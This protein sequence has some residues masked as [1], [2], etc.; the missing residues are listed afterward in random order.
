[1][2]S[3]TASPPP[4]SP[5]SSLLSAS[6]SLHDLHL[7]SSEGG[8]SDASIHPA[9]LT[10]PA[11]SDHASLRIPT[12]S[13]APTPPAPEV[14]SPRSR[15][16]KCKDV[17][18]VAIGTVVTG[19]LVFDSGVITYLHEV[20]GHI[21]L[22]G[23]LTLSYP[24]GIQPSYTV[25]Q[26]TNA[27]DMGRAGSAAEFFSALGNWLRA[28]DI[29]GDWWGHASA[30]KSGAD[31][32]DPFNALG[33]GLG[34][35]QTDAWILL[36]GQLP[37]LLSSAALVHA[38]SSICRERPLTGAYLQSLGYLQHALNL[39]YV[40]WSLGKG[41][42]ALQQAA[43]EGDDF[44]GIAV[45]LARHTGMSAPH[46]IQAMAAVLIP[47]I[48]AVG[49]VSLMHERSHTADAISDHVARQYWLR[50]GGEGTFAPQPTKQA[51]LRHMHA[52]LCES[53]RDR[54]IRRLGTANIMA[55]LSMPILRTVG[56][57]LVPPLGHAMAGVTAVWPMV[58]MT[59]AVAEA[60]QLRRDLQAPKDIVPMSATVMRGISWAATAAAAGLA[61]EDAVTWETRDDQGS[62]LGDFVGSWRVPIMYGLY[63]LSTAA[64]YL[65]VRILRDHWQRTGVFDRGEVG[66]TAADQRVRDGGAPE[67]TETWV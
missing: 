22:G 59:L 6:T 67:S 61:I 17:T 7:A 56:A 27:Q 65:R 37:W 24:H 2:A 21:V 38:G 52:P 8:Q 10:E 54:H 13:P 41:D 23:G 36:A 3:R 20:F 46:I 30:Y 31:P 63:A 47:V 51:M 43:Q 60:D 33:H 15:T 28:R 19:G 11:H 4:A 32:L 25:D 45:A 16:Q 64:A 39:I 34:K 12:P 44:A 53:P 66:V 35:D 62:K 42:A 57:T 55:Y 1:M 48:P 18:K 26:F 14:H 58:P 9:R 5:T 50:T 49:A 29:D 40:T